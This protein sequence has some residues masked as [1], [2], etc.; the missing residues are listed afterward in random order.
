[1]R[2]LLINSLKIFLLVG[3]SILFFSCEEDAQY[4]DYVYPEPTVENIYPATGYVASQIVITGTN[5]GDRIEPVK[6]LFGGVEAEKIISCKNNRIIVEVPAG[7]QSGDV[8]L[9]VWTHTLESAGR[10]TVIPTP[11][12]TAVVSDN[13]AGEIFAVGGDRV[14]IKGS[15]FGSVV[16]DVIVTINNKNAQVLSVMENEIV[17]EVPADYGSGLVTIS[18]KGY[19]VEGTAL[20]D[21]STTGD[22][23]RLFLKNYT[24][25]FQRGDNDD[26]EW[27]SALYW[28]KNDAFGGNALQFTAEVP[29]GLLVIQAGWGQPN[30][31]GGELYQ[32]TTLPEGTYDFTVTVVED[33][34][35]AGRYGVR[36]AVLKGEI[37]FPGMS[38]M[39]NPKKWEF[40]DK[41]NV[42]AETYLT[43]QTGIAEIEYT[44]TTTLT[45]TT[46]VTIGFATQMVNTNS[47]K[48]SGVKIE[49]R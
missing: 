42:L 30:K 40:T 4:K 49:R 21:P 38:E 34:K 3:F 29:Q 18:V 36:F 48:M 13:T 10:F 12:I 25:P 19:E 14:T 35:S 22:V 23:T 31:Q 26:S 1:M 32:L 46:R 5:F 33:T 9:K 20:I 7:A 15:A 16:E 44:C 45:E 17:A 8:T 24:Q 27:G 47:L 41:T 2:N 11:V 6:V 37:A 39:G 28:L 43:N